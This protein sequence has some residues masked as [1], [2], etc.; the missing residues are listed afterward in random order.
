MGHPILEIKDLSITYKN[1]KNS[2]NNLEAVKEVNFS[3][4][5]GE[6]FCLVGES[7]SGKTSIAMAIPRLLPE[8]TIVKGNIIVN[9]NPVYKS[10]FNKVNELRR[11]YISFIF[12]DSV[13]SLIPNISIRKQFR[14]VISHRLGVSENKKIIE[15]MNDALIRV[16]LTN[17]DRVLLSYPSQLSGGMCQR[18]MIAMALSV[19]PSLVIA[20]EPTASLDVLT[21]EMVLEL[22]VKLQKEF[23]FALLII[24]HDMRIASHYSDSIGVM[25]RGELIEVNKT[26]IFFKEPT[27]N[28]SKQLV[29]AAKLLSV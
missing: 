16:G 23:D 4:N 6:K 20:D 17:I 28:Y 26:D 21:Q 11:K 24:T 5:A 9:N 7:G 8:I 2:N 12:Q 25:Y 13:G 15:I 18:V 1:S 27:K 10:S 22:L 3:I 29:N 14:R 19:K